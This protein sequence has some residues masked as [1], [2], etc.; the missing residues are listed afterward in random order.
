MPRRL[1][2]KF[3]PA[4]QFL[5]D[6]WF[7]RPFGT[8]LQDPQLWTLHRRGVTPAFGAGL[9]ICFV[10]LPVHLLLACT[11]A[12]V[13]RLNIAVTCATTFLLNPFSAVPVYY[14]AYRVGAALMHAPRQHFKFVP[15]LGWF[16]HGLAPVWQP[17]V[18][19][20]LV[21]GVVAGVLGWALL[22]LLWRAQVSSRYRRRRA[23]ALLAA[24]PRPHPSPRPRPAKPS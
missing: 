20:C 5:R 16:R 7:L 4:P 19:G 1:L 15:T 24:P 21:C 22:E 3:I 23:A 2:K 12:V 9:A 11:T 14:A 17:F 6:R 10:P 13:C 8:R 18:L